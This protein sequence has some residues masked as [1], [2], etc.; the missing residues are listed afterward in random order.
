MSDQIVEIIAGLNNKAALKQHIYRNTQTVFKEF[1]RSAKE[2][3]EQL[4]PT[5]ANLSFI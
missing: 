2:I 1:L 3:A 5:V 4:A